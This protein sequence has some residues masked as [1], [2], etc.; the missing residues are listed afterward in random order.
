[1][2]AG[3][4]AN[5]FRLAASESDQDLAEVREGALEVFAAAAQAASGA[6]ADRLN[7]AAG[8]IDEL[9]RAIDLHVKQAIDDF[10][11]LVERW[12]AL[13]AASQSG[14]ADL[15]GWLLGGRRFGQRGCP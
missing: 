13:V 11:Y 12:G 9:S 4:Y 14:S 5:S 10:A 15:A 1:L 2:N 7:A 6:A 8:R 3:N